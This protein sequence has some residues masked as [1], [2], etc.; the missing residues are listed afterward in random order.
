MKK[1][2]TST[3][4]MQEGEDIIKGERGRERERK[5]SFKDPVNF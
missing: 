5:V 1:K 2:S 4:L 3:K